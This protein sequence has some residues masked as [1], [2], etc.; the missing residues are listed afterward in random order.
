ME[1]ASPVCRW[2][3][4][5]GLVALAGCQTPGSS[6][7]LNARG[8]APGELPAPLSPASLPPVIPPQPMPPAGPVTPIQP[9]PPVG[10]VTPL[11][12]VPTGSGPAVP[13]GPVQGLPVNSNVAGGSVQG[14]PVNSG[15]AGGP[16]QGFPINPGPITPV[17]MVMPPSNRPNAETAMNLQ[18]ESMPQIGNS[19]PQVKVMAQVGSFIITDQEVI[20]AVH[21]RLEELRDLA[22]SAR[23]DKEKR[24]YQ[25][26]LSK[27][28]ERELLI[29]DVFNRLKKNKKS[30][31]EIKEIGVQ[32]A[33]ERLRDIRNQQGARTEEEFTRGLSSQGLTL[34]GLRRKIERETM[35]EVYV[36]GVLKET[37]RSPGFTD[38]RRYYDQHPEEFHVADRV[39]WQGIF[40][41]F[42]N[43]SN[44]EAA[45][46]HA[47]QVRQMAMEGTDFVSLIKTEEKAPR[48]RLNWDGIGTTRQTV[49]LDVAPTV[50]ALQPGQI[51]GLI[52]TPGGY[53]IVK[54]LEREYDGLRPLDIK[55]QT[56][57]HDK[58]QRQYRENER[59]K[60]IDDLWRKGTVEIFP[61][62]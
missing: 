22:G 29:D 37:G 42:N 20:E 30:N 4:A 46:A 21:M 54:V 52:E 51:S 41:S 53:H 9:M 39:R 16:V 23:A 47:L 31:D 8:Q 40:I 48:G 26:E 35:A 15:V 5:M 27:L 56:E 18:R 45:S 49:P 43:Y 38:I 14:L 59:K 32:S 28:I 17:A 3:F 50:W 44:R 19:I 6:E 60:L 1:A 24:I 58:L 7:A 11:Q 55:V 36:H 57:C 10:P 34:A 13:S 61:T 25:E 2:L 62:H 33:D 12:P